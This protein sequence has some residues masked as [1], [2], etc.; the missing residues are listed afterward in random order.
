MPD[1]LTVSIGADTAKLRADLELVKAQA[2]ELGA[3]MRAAAAEAQ[4]IGG[5]TAALTRLS[6]AFEETTAHA[7]RMAAALRA[8]HQAGAPLTERTKAFGE[9][10]RAVREPLKSVHEGVSRLTER[11]GIAGL[12]GAITSLSFT[13]LTRQI[14]EFATSGAEAVIKTK[15][16]AD[17]LGAT[18]KE[19]QGLQLSAAQLG[20]PLDSVTN[21][22]ERLT[23]RIGEARIA[24]RSMFLVGTVTDYGAGIV[25]KRVADLK[26]LE[27]IG[28]GLARLEPGFAGTLKGMEE[29]NTKLLRITDPAE[30]AQRAF[31]GLGKTWVEFQRDLETA[32]GAEA[33]TKEI[34]RFGL[35]VTPMEE[36]AAAAFTKARNTFENISGRLRELVSNI[37]GQ[38]FVPLFDGLTQRLANNRDMIVSWANTLQ[39]YLS[40]VGRDVLKLFS[41]GRGA[42]FETGA[43]QTFVNLLGEAEKAVTLLKNAFTA[44]MG[45]LD[46]I[47]GAI[48]RTFGTEISG[49]MILIAAA[50]AQVTGALG[51]LTGALNLL[52]G[53]LSV[54]RGAFLLLNTA[55]L[56]NPFVAIGTAVAV[57]IGTIYVFRKD[58]LEVLGE[59]WNYW[60]EFADWIVNT[61]QAGMQ[62]VAAGI[63]SIWEA[64]L[65]WLGGMFE[66]L[67]ELA[68]SFLGA[69]SH[70]LGSAGAALGL[71]GR[72]TAAS[73]LPAGLAAGGPVPG[74]GSRDSV[75]ALLAPGEFVTRAAAVQH[76]GAAFFQALNARA[77]PRDWG[78]ELGGLVD[79]LHRS[80]R[81][82]AEGGMVAGAATTPVHLHIGGSSFPLSATASVAGALVLEGRRQQMTS[83]GV[84]P[85][86]LGSGPRR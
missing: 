75:P 36:R 63:Q 19:V 2:R 54:V 70:A 30:R 24:Q 51:L 59:V 74:T 12:L 60:K 31:E 48:N 57:L 55:M 84:R 80:P 37:I 72:A 33:A 4:K 68:K 11:L 28:V 3:Q 35:A 46:S 17:T 26:G 7:Q 34:E 29:I 27:A 39:T 56:A 81:H 53:V 52:A 78:Y 40:A 64:P 85:A 8:A 71:A 77:L 49:R 9:S 73:P 1:N 6:A 32:R 58:I 45:V 20:R 66:R 50:V 44:L 5:D 22:M 76:Y 10:L 69:A 16:L 83:I 47:A 79:S 38:A 62:A 25:N 82:F 14:D 67:T 23:R 65:R 13:E 21:S 18:S 41:A 43:M 61:F 86:W 15:D 42:Q